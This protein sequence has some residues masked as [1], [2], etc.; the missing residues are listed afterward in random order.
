ME[1]SIPR[2]QGLQPLCRQ[3]CQAGDA[4]A[5]KRCLRLDEKGG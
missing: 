4:H 5:L 2:L 3:S 1:S